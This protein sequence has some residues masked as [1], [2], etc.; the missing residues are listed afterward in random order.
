MLVED[1]DKVDSVDRLDWLDRDEVL[2]E[3]CVLA[4]DCDDSDDSV[5]VEELLADD[6]S[7]TDW[8]L[9]L[10]TLLVELLD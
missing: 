10:L 7:A 1:D 5:L 9:G 6:S 3:L 4:D 2:L 8:L